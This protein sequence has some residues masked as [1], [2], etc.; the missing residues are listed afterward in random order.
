MPTR[1]LHTI[2]FLLL[3]TSFYAQMGYVNKA[4]VVDNDTISNI[5]LSTHYVVGR[6]KF[7]NKRQEIRYTRLV[8]YVKKVYPYAKLAGEKLDSYDSLLR[9]TPNERDR[10]KIMKQAEKDIRAEYEGK[11]RKFTI[12]QG[13]ILVK[14]IDRETNH[15]SYKLLKEL[16]GSVSAIL[17]QGVGRIFGYNLKIKY[18]PAG[19][20]KD[21]E[22]IIQ[23]IDI[24]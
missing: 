10:K 22:K 4:I 6:K 21:I 11:L 17:W 15:S 23:L 16:R 9:V 13:K 7:E 1:I 2:I 8:R 19:E 12:G 3:S 18:D 24:G 20:D 14:L 5:N